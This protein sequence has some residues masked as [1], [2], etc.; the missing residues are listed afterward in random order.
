MNIS[1][2]NFV[3]QY[4]T[5]C[6]TNSLEIHYLFTNLT[7]TF[8]NVKM[9]DTQKYELIAKQ[10]NEFVNFVYLKNGVKVDDPWKLRA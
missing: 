9:N 2:D 10:I 6:K 3:E 5:K 4:E 7:A 1:S 8:S